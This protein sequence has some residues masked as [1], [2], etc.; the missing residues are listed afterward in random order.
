MPSEYSRRRLRPAA[1]SRVHEL[2]ELVHPAR[3]DADQLRGDREDLAAAAAVVLRGRV[4]QDADP[5][6]GVRERVVGRVQHGRVAGIGVRERAQHAQ[7]RRLA[8]PV[9]TEEPGHRA[10]LAAKRDVAHD[11]AP[12]V[13]LG[14]SFCLDHG[15]EDRGCAP[16]APAPAVER[17]IDFGRGSLTGARR[18][19]R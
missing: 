5:A 11:R 16:D 1:A 3:V 6:P 17:W 10:G 4:E 18:T 12:S 19:L 14:Q 15:R 8:G 2:Q 9:G 13:A 7:R